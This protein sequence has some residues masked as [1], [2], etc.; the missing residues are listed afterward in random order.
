MKK[1][2]YSPHKHTHLS[3]TPTFRDTRMNRGPSNDGRLSK[4]T[5]SSSQ[6]SALMWT[7]SSS[8]SQRKVIRMM[9]EHS[10]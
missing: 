3:T 4:A 1:V 9:K 2:R 8:D 5:T 10:E 6:P 7:L